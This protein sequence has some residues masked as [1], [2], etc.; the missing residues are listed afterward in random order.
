MQ[1]DRSASR[2][3]P[4]WSPGPERDDAPYEDGGVDPGRHAE[5][6]ARG[7]FVA[8]SD[9]FGVEVL[10]GAGLEASPFDECS[11]FAVLAAG[12]QR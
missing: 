5:E 6:G 1:R 12:R 8:A 7:L 4:L 3:A 9:G 10:E 2:V 11:T